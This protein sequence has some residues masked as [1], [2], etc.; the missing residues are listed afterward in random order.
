MIINVSPLII[1]Q[2]MDFSENGVIENHNKL[3]SEYWV[4]VTYTLFISVMKW[5][6]EIVRNKITGELL[7]VNEVNVHGEMTGEDVNTDSF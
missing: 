6:L 4:T 2:D 5:L 7:V 3:H 1:Q